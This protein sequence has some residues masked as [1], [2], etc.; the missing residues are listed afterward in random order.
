MKLIGNLKKQVE[1]ENTMEGRKSLIE[2]AGMLLT[3]DELDKVAG[4]CQVN[5]HPRE[6]SHLGHGSYPGN[7]SAASYMEW[8]VQHPDAT[9]AEIREFWESRR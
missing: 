2:K 4:G 6:D 5:P 9:E 8:Q 1:N 3:D 7:D